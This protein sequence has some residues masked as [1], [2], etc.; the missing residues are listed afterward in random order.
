MVDL[1]RWKLHVKVAHSGINASD[2]PGGRILNLARRE[3]F[4]VCNFSALDR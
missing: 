1:E 2:F 4:F 3:K